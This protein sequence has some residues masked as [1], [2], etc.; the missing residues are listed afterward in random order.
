[1]GSVG[2]VGIGSVLGSLITVIVTH[3]LEKGKLKTERQ[4]NLQREVYFKLQEQTEKLFEAIN[5]MGRQIEEIKFWLQKGNFVP[6]TNT[7]IT[8]RISKIS[9]LQAYFPKE[10]LEKYNE[11]A[12][13]FH[14]IARI[15]FE[16]G[17][18]G[19]L[20]Q[21]G[22]DSINKSLKEFSEKSNELVR[23]VL[24]EL[25]KSKTLII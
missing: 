20:S 11:T 15:Y 1:M 14:E 19:Y 17:K 22:S 9:S 13:V 10:I 6:I 16:T 5:L 18:I 21:Q 23:D 25:E 3:F 7:P 2:L 12:L 8:E 24:G 4:S